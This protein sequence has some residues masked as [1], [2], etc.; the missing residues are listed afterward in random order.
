MQGNE[1]GRTKEA[2]GEVANGPLER[3]DC[4]GFGVV[5]LV[6]GVG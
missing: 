4:T 1:K 2:L 6:E 3:A 5:V